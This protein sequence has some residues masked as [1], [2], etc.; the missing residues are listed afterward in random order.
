VGTWLIVWLIASLTT[1]VALV[2]FVAALVRHGLVVG[3]SAQRMQAEI[4]PLAEEISRESAEQQ[5][6]LSTL[7]VPGRRSDRA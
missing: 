4:A 1:M 7:K 6:R 2:A 3:R 5:R